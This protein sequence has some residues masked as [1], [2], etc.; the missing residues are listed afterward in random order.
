MVIVAGV[1]TV[2]NAPT[3]P[4]FVMVVPVVAT[5]AYVVVPVVI[6]VFVL[7]VAVAVTH[8]YLVSY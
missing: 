5:V 8:G 2:A 4:D 1:E 7:N 6:V 3:V